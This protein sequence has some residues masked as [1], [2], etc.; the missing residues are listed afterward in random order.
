MHCVLVI[1]RHAWLQNALV[2]SGCV[3]RTTADSFQSISLKPCMVQPKLQGR[4]YPDLFKSRERRDGGIPALSLLFFLP[5]LFNRLAYVL[6]L[7]ALA[8]LVVLHGFRETEYS[9]AARP[10]PSSGSEEGVG[11][12]VQGSLPGPPLGKPPYVACYGF[13]TLHVSFARV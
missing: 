7:V 13:C 2:V 11:C 8:V 6:P 10:S 12:S 1:I 5:L 9:P 3:A 4:V